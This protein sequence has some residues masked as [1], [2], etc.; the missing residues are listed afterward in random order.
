MCWWG[1]RNPDTYCWGC[2]PS[3][4]VRTQRL[5]SNESLWILPSASWPPTLTNNYGACGP[6]SVRHRSLWQGDFSQES[7][8]SNP[9]RSLIS[10]CGQ[11]D[12]H[13][14]LV[15]RLLFSYEL[16]EEDPRDET[17]A[18]RELAPL[19]RWTCLLLLVNF[20]AEQFKKVY[21]YNNGSMEC[22]S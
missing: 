12:H 5:P 19:G 9:Q 21:F 13:P 16:W 11:L 1:Q 15:C 22:R 18:E 14:V 2:C 8:A 7:P 6:D 20:K 4:G 17:Q 10:F 3:A